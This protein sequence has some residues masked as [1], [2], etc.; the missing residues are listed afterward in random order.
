MMVTCCWQPEQSYSICTLHVSFP[1]F[2]KST[3]NFH[4]QYIIAHDLTRIN[5]KSMLLATIGK[6]AGYLE[7]LWKH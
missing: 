5:V 1:I 3:S 2:P 6:E 4:L 7:E